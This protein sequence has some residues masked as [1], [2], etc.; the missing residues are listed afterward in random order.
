MLTLQWGHDVR[1]S[2]PAAE[3]VVLTER[4]LVSFGL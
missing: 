4:F 2:S 3:A 1:I